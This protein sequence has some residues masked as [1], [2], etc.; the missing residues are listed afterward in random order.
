MVGKA[1][2]LIL[3]LGCGLAFA[4]QSTAPVQ[5]PAAQA[6][7]AATSSDAPGKV[8]S[9]APASSQPAGNKSAPDPANAANADATGPVTI[10]PPGN[11]NSD[12]NPYD[13]VLEP[14]PLPKSKT[15]LIGGL[16]TNVDHVR[17]HV[18][19]QPF[20]GGH[21]VKVF[22]D[23]RSHL[24]RNG[25]PTTI[26]GVHKG[27]HVYVDTM[28]ADNNK[29]LARNLRV[30]TETGMAEVRGQVIS[31]NPARG[32][33]SVRDQ[34]SE[35]PV[36]FAVGSTTQ[37]S[38]NKGAATLADIA[39]GSLIDV[40]FSPRRDKAVAKQVQLLAKPGDNY[41]FTG[42]VTNI[43][44]R[45]NSFYVDNKSDDQS[46]EVHFAPGAVS[47]VRALRIGSQV[48]ARAV[49]DGKAYVASNVR[50]ENGEQNETGA[51]SKA[52]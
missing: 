8:D 10:L 50:V 51:Q 49:F 24:Y 42:V 30:I 28:L 31:S 45:T 4:Q 43:D 18:T 29:I 38:S 9:N 12:D 17:N 35:R 22:V 41:I 21:K 25:A 48:T 13:P 39:P 44:M 14:P 3:G 32:V 19:V 2:V 33:I 6:S 34:L 47:D 7:Q 15:T 20:G 5:Q 27:D 46:Y 52:Q 1:L 36:T 23:E 40:Q 26:L 11:G 16:A 37:Y